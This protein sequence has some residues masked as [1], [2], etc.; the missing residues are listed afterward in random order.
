MRGP[1]LGPGLSSAA[2]RPAG[3]LVDRFDAA[4]ARLLGYQRY[5]IDGIARTGAGWQR[6]ATR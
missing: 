6:R 3:H 2:V 1:V 4:P 5:H